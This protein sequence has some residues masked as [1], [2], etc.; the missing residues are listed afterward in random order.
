MLKIQLGVE[1]PTDVERVLKAFGKKLGL[2]RPATPEEVKADLV[3]YIQQTV[4]QQ[5]TNALYTAAGDAAAQIPP[6]GV[7][8][9]KPTPEGKK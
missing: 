9:D 8:G 2:D 1:A 5:E 4:T 7:D 6:V 3:K